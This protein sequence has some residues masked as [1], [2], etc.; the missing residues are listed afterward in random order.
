[1]QA[2]SAEHATQRNTKDA[3]YVGE[4]ARPPIPCSF[5]NDRPIPETRDLALRGE[6]TQHLGTQYSTLFPVHPI[7]HV[8]M[9]FMSL[10]G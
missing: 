8:P 10:A 5:L 6:A 2:L 9:F 7:T 3:A 4:A 1:M